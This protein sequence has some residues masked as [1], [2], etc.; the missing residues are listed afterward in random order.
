MY[1]SFY[2]YNRFRCVCVCVKTFQ[3]ISLHKLLNS[4]REIHSGFTVFADS[5]IYIRR[6]INTYNHTNTCKPTVSGKYTE[7][8]E[9]YAVRYHEIRSNISKCSR[10]CCEVQRERA[11]FTG[12]DSNRTSH[13]FGGIYGVIC[14]KI[15]KRY[16]SRAHCIPKPRQRL[17]RLSFGHTLRAICPSITMHSNPHPVLVVTFTIAIIRRKLRRRILHDVD[18]R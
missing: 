6:S 9:L 17:N 10:A 11:E 16:F 1:I 8:F 13:K 2:M 18:A 4:Q 12:L 5:N 3:R 7:L 14:Y 15:E